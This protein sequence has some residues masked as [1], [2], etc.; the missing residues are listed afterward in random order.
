M[1]FQPATPRTS[2]RALLESADTP[3]V[4]AG[5]EPGAVLFNQGDSCETVMHIEEGVVRLAITSSS[6]REAICGLLSTGAFLSEEVLGGHTV[7][8]HTA[9]AVTATEVLIVAKAHVTDLIHT[10]D[11]M[12]NRFVEHIVARHVRLEDDLTDQ[13]LHSGEQRLARALLMLAGCGLESPDRRALPRISQEVIAEMVGTTRARV[14]AFMGKF[15]KL[16][17]LEQDGA[18]IHVNP[19]LLHVIDSHRPTPARSHAGVSK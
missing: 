1:R 16:G 2:L 15:K 9:T 4:A 12:R 8:R 6:G 10:H 17:F 7:Q 14:N 11:A 5:Y 18:V 3:F 19:S 13:L